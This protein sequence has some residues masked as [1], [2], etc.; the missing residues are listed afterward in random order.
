M[1]CLLLVA[2]KERKIRIEVG[3]GLEGDL[4]DAHSKRIIDEVMVPLFRAGHPESG[5]LLGVINIAER[6][7]PQAQFKKYFAGENFRSHREVRQKKSLV[8]RIF[9]IY[10]F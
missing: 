6:T 7:D 3:Q 5:I 2:K 4:T 9:S 8:S 10:F 1:E